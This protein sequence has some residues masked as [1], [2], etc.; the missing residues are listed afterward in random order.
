M[1]EEFGAQIEREDANILIRLDEFMLAEIHPLALARR[2]AHGEPKGGCPSFES[3]DSCLQEETVGRRWG[4][5]NERGDGPGRSLWAA[6]PLLS[7]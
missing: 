1:N 5:T 6:R 3:T 2:G 7:S 4:R